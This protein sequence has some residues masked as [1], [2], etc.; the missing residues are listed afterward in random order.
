MTHSFGIPMI[1]K[2]TCFVI[3]VHYKC[4]LQCTVL[5]LKG[6]HLTVISTPAL[7]CYLIIYTIY[8]PQFTLCSQ[9]QA[10]WSARKNVHMFKLPYIF[11][12]IECYKMVIIGFQSTLL[13][14]YICV[15]THGNLKQWESHFHH[16]DVGGDGNVRSVLSNYF[17]QL[18][19]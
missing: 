5:C 13:W 10:H 14:C 7:F 19:I 16:G 11:C 4:A 2:N 15:H 18:T 1:M 9:V 3:N 6:Q 17:P 8:Q 12:S